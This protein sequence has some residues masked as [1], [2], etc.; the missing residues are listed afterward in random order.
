MAATY[1]AVMLTRKG[2]P[3][4]L[5]IVEFPI[6]PP[7][8][9]QLRVRVR[10]AGV[11][12]T[13]LIVLSGKYRYAPKIP[14]VP[15]YEVAGVVE[16]VGPGVT[17]F[18]V[19]DRVAALTVYGS[20]AELLVREAEVFL[21]IP[22]GVSDRDAA[23]VILNY[24]T[25][26]QMIHRVADVKPGQTA[27]VTGAAGGVGTAALQLLRLAGVRTYGAASTPK[28]DTLRSLGATPIDYRAG[29]IDRLIHALQPQGVDY[30]FDAVGGANIGPCIGALRRGGMLVGFGFMAAS[31][32]LSQLAMFANIFLGARLRGRRGA[33]YGITRLY[34]KDPKPLRED[35]SKIF[36]LLAEKKIDPLINRT[37][38]LLDAG[39]A[40]ELLATGSVG[41]KIVLTNG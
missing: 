18:K 27:L 41:G 5:Q 15:G 11:G 21:P 34:R 9:G 6:E 3:E 26:W 12:A 29:S 37:F 24:I 8:P 4:V 17:D 13:D 28:H 33:F 2:G 16:A 32:T 30:A 25:A 22:D 40:L 38:P 7:G 1:R 20:F 19:G 39:K 10:A 23:A 36:S 14:L 31:T 35:L